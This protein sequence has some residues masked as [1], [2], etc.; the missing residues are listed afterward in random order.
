MRQHTVPCALFLG[1]LATMASAAPLTGR[2]VTEDGLALP[3]R[4]LAYS[5]QTR[6]SAEVY[7]KPDGS[8]T[9]DV[10]EGKLVLIATHGPEW[11]VAQ[12]E[13]T[14]EQVCT[15]SLKRLVDMPARG[16]YGA[17]LHMHSTASDGKQSPTEVAY[18]CRAAGLHIAALSDH[19][20]VAGHGEWLAQA[21]PDFLPLTAQEITTSLGHVVGVN[22]RQQV[23]N[24]VTGGALDFQRIFSKVHGQ[25]GFAIV[26]HPNAPGM[27]YQAPEVR[28][29]DALEILNGSIP[30]Y[31]GI[32][33]FVQGRKAWHSL[34][35][36][37]L[38]IACV[39]NS[40]NHDNLS[41]MPRTI[42]HD[43]SKAAQLDKRIGGLMKLV[44]FEKV[45]EPWAWKGLHPGF[46]RTY[47]QLSETTPEAVHAAVK[48]GHGFVTNGPLIFAKLD[49]QGPGSEIKVN[50][51]AFLT[52]SL[53]MIANR[54]LEKFVVLVSGQP[55]TTLPVPAEP[56]QVTVPVKPGDWVA[57][58]LYGV[59]PEFATTN[60]WYIK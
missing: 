48:Q 21:A 7:T 57:V 8:F 2:V 42:L 27:T 22:I 33:D 60:A 39:G 53:E 12:V 16:Y 11:S 1:L 41:S 34:L 51:R 38:R 36:Q 50:E 32:F 25:S 18:G 59:W 44:D 5:P 28:E 43:P 31:G 40:D 10:P 29:Y 52:M 47:L 54:P 37:G 4:V 13:A 46:Y 9:L 58:E 23:S 15:L 19:E 14:A 45:L 49:D 6:E 56:T 30:P 20:T 35:S 24:D 3:A 17:D 26:A 55:V